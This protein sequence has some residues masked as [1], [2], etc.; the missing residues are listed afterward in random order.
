MK[1]IKKYNETSLVV[2]I[3]CGLAIGLLLALIVPKV[4]KL[5]IIGN[6]F[7]GALRG[8]APILVF[9][10]VTSALVNG[11]GK[12]DRRFGSVIFLYMLSTFLA[13]FVAVAGSFLFP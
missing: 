1:I 10:L 6:I 7:I 12:M 8:I 9:A 5:E 4:L 2:R 11:S 13:A 3:I